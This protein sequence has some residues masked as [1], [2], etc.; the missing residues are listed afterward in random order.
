MDFTREDIDKIAL[1]LSLRGIKDSS[2]PTV[3][4]PL[5]GV[6]TI[7]ILQEGLNKVV[8]LNDLN[9]RLSNVLDMDVYNVSIHSSLNGSNK[10]TLTEAISLVPSEL[11]RLG[12]V[13]IFIG[14]A[15]NLL[16][17]Y[18]F[19]GTTIDV[20]NDITQWELLGGQVV[21]TLGSSTSDYMSQGAIQEA[22]NS[23]EASLN[24]LTGTLSIN[25][26]YYPI[27]VTAN[28]VLTWNYNADIIS[29]T[30]N[31]STI[32]VSLRTFSESI[33]TNKL[34]T[35]I[36]NSS[37]SRLVTLNKT[38]KFVNPYYIGTST[39]T[40]PASSD[41]LAMT[42]YADDTNNI[43]NLNSKVINFNFTGSRMV[44]A[45]P[46]TKT[47]SAIK[48]PNGFNITSSFTT[49]SLTING[50]AYT[51]WVFNNIVDANGNYTIITSN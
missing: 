30:I 18:G 42:S 27:G 34:Y 31:S 41:I 39:L 13:I 29:Q 44:I 24:P 14:S 21:Q 19:N 23:L 2:F 40:S 37:Y 51:I 45:I 48:D 25:R 10:F 32:L 33:T 47:I 28:V 6:E 20:W 12:Q 17:R 26:Y 7:P 15:D 36:G 35:L 46:S 22:L 3:R 9:L 38:V 4:L 8:P 49:S 5:T 43:D 11:I 1:Q 16:Y 50:I